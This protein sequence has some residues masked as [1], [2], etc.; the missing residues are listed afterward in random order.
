MRVE[1][2]L[3]SP[4]SKASAKQRAGRAGRTKPGKCFRLYTEQS[5]NEELIENNYPEILRSNLASTVL[6]L[7][8]LGI[9][10]LVHFDFMDPPAPETM[11]RALELLN[12]LGALDDEGTL[13]EDGKKMAEF[14]LEPQLSKVLL[15]APRFNCVNEILTIVAC[16]NS[17]NIFLRP[18]EK[19]VEASDAH[20]KFVS[21][22]GDHL[23]LMNAFFEYKRKNQDVDWC[24]KNFL[25]HRHLKSTFDVR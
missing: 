25:N 24:F 12:Y 4:I 19:Q 14:P 9:D 8:K 2:L 22:D 18:K 16:L 1:S 10:D 13:T 3:V 6:T 23:T 11:M 15:S 21:Q 17:P 5:Y 20:A 7:K